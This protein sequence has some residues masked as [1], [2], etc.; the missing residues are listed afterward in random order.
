MEVETWKRAGESLNE[1]I[2]RWRDGR[3]LNA[4]S[5]APVLVMLAGAA[6]Y[7]SLAPSL[8][9]SWVLPCAVAIGAAYL[10]GRAAVVRRCLRDLDERR[11]SKRVV[12][13]CFDGLRD[14]GTRIFHDVSGDGCHLDHVIISRRGVFVVAT[15]AVPK[16]WPKAKVYVDGRRLMVAGRTPEHDPRVG[17]AAAARWVES[18]LRES[19]GK[20]FKARAIVAYPGWYVQQADPR[21]SV[22]VIDPKALPALLDHETTTVAA[23]DV[24]L[25]A[26]HLSRYV[27][28]E[29]A[30][31]ELARAA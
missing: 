22:W 18:F 15:L 29:P 20:R 28:T 11:E 14:R 13:R 4:F 2:R 1:K 26:W 31:T 6:A 3:I 10:A 19:T 9:T 16:P 8:K 30:R 12:A 25:A 21:G 7:V 17:V 27:R 5:F 24:A 23:A